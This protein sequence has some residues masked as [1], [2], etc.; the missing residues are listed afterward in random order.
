MTDSYRI[1]TKKSE[2]DK[3]LHLLE[4]ILKGIS[5]DS[6]VNEEEIIELGNWINMHEMFSHLYPYKEIYEMLEDILEDGLVTEDEKEDLLWFC[7]KVATT[8]TYYDLITSDIQ[9]LH[10]IVRGIIADKTITTDEIEKLQ[11]WLYSNEQL[12][13][14]Y[15]YDE[16]TSLISE[17][18]SDGIVTSDEKEMIERFFLEFVDTTTLANYTSQE[19]EDI[20]SNISLGGICAL[21]PEINLENATVVFTGKSSR[22]DRKKFSEIV[23]SFGGRIVSG[24]SKK[25][26]YLVVGDNGNPCWSYACYGRKIE[27]AIQL[28]SEGVPIIIVHENDFWD[29]LLE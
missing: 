26:N 23:E 24:V 12:T 19:I 18:L 5:Y 25:V 6:V 22:C 10:G 1:F 17:V 4:G 16:L 2:S 14:T 11:D 20:K 29:E 7:N 9:R 3:A 21:A 8:N 27:Q 13:S 15:P 28:R